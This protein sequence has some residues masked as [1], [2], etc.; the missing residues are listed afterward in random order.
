MTA[1]VF[2]HVYCNDGIIT[3]LSG[4]GCIPGNLGLPELLNKKFDKAGG[5]VDG[6]VSALSY[7]VRGTGGAHD[8]SI[9]PASGSGAGMAFMQYHLGTEWLGRVG[10][11]K[12]PLGE[13]WEYLHTG[14][15]VLGLSQKLVNVT[16]Q[17][18]KG[19]LYYN[20]TRQPMMIAIS[21]LYSGPGTGVDA[22]LKIDD[23]SFLARGGGSV[24]EGAYKACSLSMI[25]PPGASY[26][27]TSPTEARIESW[28]EL[29]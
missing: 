24:S 17:R 20:T 14:S 13:T 18:N 23:V 15:K 1:I 16:N 2:P 4:Y 8:L 22:V 26:I 21:L 7:T 19:V 11:P 6:D 27:L 10:V 28:V 5:E 25:I 12:I 3:D 29:R 9:Y